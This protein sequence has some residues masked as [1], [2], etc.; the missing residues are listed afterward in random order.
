MEEALPPPALGKQ[1]ELLAGKSSPGGRVSSG[2]H[3]RSDYLPEHSK[4]EA[5]RLGG[6]LHAGTTE[7]TG[8]EAAVTG[9]DGS[10]RPLPLP[11]PRDS[12]PGI[13]PQDAAWVVSVNS[14]KLMQN[15]NT[16]SCPR[17]G[18]GLLKAGQAAVTQGSVGCL[19]V[20][21][22]SPRMAVVAL[23]GHI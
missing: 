3:A 8:T 15:R 11:L 9:T 18:L 13:S 5:P 17:T 20:A 2:S 4:A 12:G 23:W 1:T 6:P 10:H 7:A 22:C 16:K 21:R 14:E 19:A